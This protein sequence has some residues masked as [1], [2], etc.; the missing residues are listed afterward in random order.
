[1]KY[2]EGRVLEIEKEKEEKL[3]KLRV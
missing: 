1:L 3:V 2:E